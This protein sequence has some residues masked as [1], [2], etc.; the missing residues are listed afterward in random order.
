MNAFEFSG[1]AQGDTGVTITGDIAEI[2]GFWK[3]GSVELAA[4][5]APGAEYRITLDLT[6][7][8]ST[9]Y[10]FVEGS[11]GA[12]TVVLPEFNAAAVSGIGVVYDGTDKLA[13]EGSAE[14][15]D[16]LVTYNVQTGKTYEIALADATQAINAG[17]YDFDV[18]VT[19]IHSD[20][21]GYASG[22]EEYEK[23]AT[24]HVTL[25]VD[26]APL[27]VSRGQGIT[28]AYNGS[29]QKLTDYEGFFVFNGA[30]EAEKDEMLA[31]IGATYTLSGTT[32]A[33]DTFTGA[34]VYSVVLVTDDPVFGNYTV[35]SRVTTL[36][37]GKA[38][39]IV[40]GTKLEGDITSGDKFGIDELSVEPADG[41]AVPES[42]V[43]KLTASVTYV[44]GS[45][46]VGTITSAG[47]YNYTVALS[48][49]AN[50]QI[51][52]TE[53]ASLGT[54]GATGTIT[55]SVSTVQTGTGEGEQ[56]VQQAEIVFGTPETKP[57]V[58]T[59]TE[60]TSGTTYNSYESIVSRTV[61][62][63]QQAEIDGVISL[64]LTNGTEVINASS[65][66]GLS[67]VSE[68]TVKLPAA[69]G[70]S[71]EGYTVYER[72][73]DGSLRAIDG[74]VN[75]GYFTYNSSIVSDLVF[76][77]IIGAGVPVW[78]WILVGVLAALIIF[79]IILAVFIGRKDRSTPPPAA[80]AE[81]P[82]A[83]EPPSHDGALP[84]ASADVDIPDAPSHI[85]GSEERPPLIGTR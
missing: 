56:F 12:V 14:L 8:T 55:V 25:T 50:Y 37:V 1:F 51:V 9:N 85:G 23:S 62:L 45:A 41:C 46:S 6:K 52:S 40:L 43:E 19:V 34:G 30:V 76:V 64:T 68:I 16:S 24:V 63:G 29:A 47:R 21:E 75:D 11:V 59:A 3:D 79:A 53:N 82:A 18:V 27:T 13:G 32:D 31:A 48:D 39:V 57:W 73:K 33:K 74:V 38:P 69:V 81:P 80:P 84:A 42:T 67:S 36:N 10:V 44:S 4:N 28:V 78:I 72:Q 66:A 65:V 5:A 54:V 61:S 17:S 58:L 15:L 20:L 77:R 7:A 70:S 71:L 26:K 2:V 60:L 49:P 22:N 83:P 35:T